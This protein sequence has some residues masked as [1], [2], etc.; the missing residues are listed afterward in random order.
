MRMT[1][2]TRRKLVVWILVVVSAWPLVHHGLTRGLG[3]NP[4][5]WFGWSMYAVP[6]GRVRVFPHTL[7]DRPLGVAQM[8]RLSPDAQRRLQAAYQ[9]F[10]RMCEGFGENAEPDGFA[11]ALLEAY[12][13]VDGVKLD[14]EWIG[15]TRET[16]MYERQQLSSF[17]YRRSGLDP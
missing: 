17:V 7:D 16:G 9:Q 1:F 4:W 12:P 13:G 6:S 11:R 3:L 8:Q 10:I 2:E 5:K 14:V 15:M